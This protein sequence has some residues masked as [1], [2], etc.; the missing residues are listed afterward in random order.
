MAKVNHNY[1]I[2]PDKVTLPQK[3]HEK[4]LSFLREAMNNFIVDYQPPTSLAVALSGGL[5]SA[6]AL[7][8]SLNSV[9][10]DKT[11]ALVLEHDYETQGEK[12][13]SHVREEL[14]RMY[15]PQVKRVDIT[16]LVN[17]HYEL[18]KEMPAGKQQEILK[19]ESIS[20]ARANAIETIASK[21]SLL[22]IDTSNLTE[23]ALG[24]LTRGDY[25]G[26]VG[27]FNCL[28]KSEVYALAKSYGL[29]GFVLEQEKR[30]SEFNT[31]HKQM[32]GADYKTLEPVIWAYINNISSPELA[33][34]SGHS[35]DW[36]DTIYERITNS[37]FRYSAH[38]GPT[39]SIDDYIESNKFY[40]NGILEVNESCSE[41]LKRELYKE[42]NKYFPA[43]TS[44]PK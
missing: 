34:I 40:V 36:I 31:T 25:C 11:T 22:V 6:T 12:K 27:I 42:R 5:D 39:A 1:A 3:Y 20:R 29:P 24:N 17:A 2:D 41:K 19:A 26:D 15:Q 18:I 10:P 23:D 8:G 28:F 4:S 13:D 14:I 44:A 30:I 16:S 37:S 9:G 21:E 38:G 7:A 43:L 35:K 32:F 33:G